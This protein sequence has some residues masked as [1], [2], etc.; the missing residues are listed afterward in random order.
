MDAIP[1]STH[2]TAILVLSLLALAGVLALVG[3]LRRLRQRR[4]LAAGASG[5]MASALIGIAGLSAALLLNL[6]TY[7]RFTHETPVAD[8][9]IMAL[10]A[11]QFRITL[12]EPDGL[13]H[14]DVRGDDWQLDARVIKWRGFATWLGLDPLYRLD[15]LSGRY[16]DIEAEQRAPRTTHALAAEP[17]LNVWQLSERLA[18]YLP[19]MDAYYGSATY[20]PLADGAHYRVTLS[21]TGLLARPVNAAAEQAVTRWR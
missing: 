13:R 1:S 5:L 2:T 15:R 14:F 17:G 8:L 3:T 7:R 21:T 9:R 16:R 6:Q 20:L 10:G 19:W 18:P 4:L 12:F 11:Q